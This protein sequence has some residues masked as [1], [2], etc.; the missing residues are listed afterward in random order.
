MRGVGATALVAEAIP[1]SVVPVLV[2]LTGLGD[3]AFLAALV[4][5][6]YVFGPRYELLGRRPAATVVAIT[7]FALSATIF[8]KY[9]FDMPR[10]PPDVMLIPEDGAGFPS[11]HATGAAATYVGLAAFLDGPSRST[12]YGVAGVLVVMVALTRVLLGVHY[13]V[14]VVAG[15]IVG[16]L[17][18]V[19]VRWVAEEGLTKA[20]A[21]AVPVAVAGT[22]L[23]PTVE[24][25]LLAGLVSG[26]TLG[27]WLASERGTDEKASTA[28]QATVLVTGI[29]LL[30]LGYVSG[31]P[32]VAGLAG[33]GSGALFLA[34]PGLDP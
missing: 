20:F 15:V 4:I 14:D 29:A 8:L 11:G 30:G 28:K 19:A 9:G 17:A 10:P 6:L 34:A 1:A 24:N 5:L 33:A 25:A 16:V 7:L 18:V 22:L 31:V 12:R 32:V 21:M 2:L 3:P 26:A 27:W 23:A 13:L